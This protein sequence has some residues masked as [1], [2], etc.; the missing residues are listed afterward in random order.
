[1]R[2]FIKPSCETRALRIQ[3]LAE[4]GVRVRMTDYSKNPRY[5]SQNACPTRGLAAHA[6]T[7]A[8]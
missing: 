1:M 5:C 4:F 3:M 6:T 2:W 8:L 7:E